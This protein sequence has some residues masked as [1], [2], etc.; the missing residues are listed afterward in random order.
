MLGTKFDKVLYILIIL[1][2]YIGVSCSSGHSGRTDSGSASLSAIQQSFNNATNSVTSISNVGSFSVICDAAGDPTSSVLGEPEYAGEN[3]FCKLNTN[4][5][6]PDT[7][8]G[9]YFI[10]SAVLCAIENSVSFQYETTAT[11]HN[12]ITFSESDSCFGSGGFDANGDADV[13]DIIPIA[14]SDMAMSV[15]DYDYYIGIQLGATTYNAA[16]EPDVRFYLKDSSSGVMAARVYQEGNQSFFEFVIDSN[17]NT[18]FYEN[19]DYAN[20]RHIRL[21][22]SGTINA[23][24]GAFTSV[25]GAHYIYTQDDVGDASSHSV[26]MHFDGTSDLYDHHVNGTRDADYSAIGSFTYD[27]DFY[28]WGVRAV[29]DNNPDTDAIL[30][31]STINMSF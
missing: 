24:T 6:S 25:N 14:L 15:G 5:K 16:A 27:P 1:L 10:V 30:D 8:Q 21:S 3:V 22:A 31:L 26:M 7:V 9:S 20:N 19:K 13:D 11:E 4:S 12:D 23:A 29:T 2:C 18:F 17:N 28:T